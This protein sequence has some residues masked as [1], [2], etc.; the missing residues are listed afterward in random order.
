VASAET[1][2]DGVV[3]HVDR[4]GYQHARQ[5]QREPVMPDRP[6]Q[7]SDPDPELER[8]GVVDQVGVGK[9]HGATR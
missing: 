2:V 6:Q 8:A 4:V 9:A 7:Q 3:D 5:D 1:Q